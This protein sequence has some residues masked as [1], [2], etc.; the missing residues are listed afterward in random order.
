MTWTENQVFAAAGVPL[1]VSVESAVIDLVLSDLV[2][3]IASA[4]IAAAGVTFAPALVTIPVKVGEAAGAFVARAA[5]R[6]VWEDKVPTIAP[7]TP[8]PPPALAKTNA[9][10]AS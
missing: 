7:Q 10:V 6:S 2:T 4:L 3:S 5:T 8:P 9:H 1:K